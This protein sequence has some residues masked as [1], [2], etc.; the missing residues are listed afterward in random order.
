MLKSSRSKCTPS[1]IHCCVDLCYGLIIQGELVDL[2][3]IA[4]QLTHDFDLEFVQLTL[5]D[6]VC[7]GNHWDDVHLKQVAHYF[8][9]ICLKYN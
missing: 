4:N 8:L 3:S 6:G 9:K 7:F 5:T 1:Y 2:D